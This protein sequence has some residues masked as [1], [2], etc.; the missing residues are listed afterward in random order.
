MC[1]RGLWHCDL[2]GVQFLFNVSG[3]VRASDSV[4]SEAEL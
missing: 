1:L 4:A 2:D 3:C